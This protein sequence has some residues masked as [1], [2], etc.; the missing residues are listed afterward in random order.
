MK[1]EGGSVRFISMSEDVD[2][3]DVTFFVCGSS[4]ITPTPR[5]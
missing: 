5:P 1:L 3:G 4:N 2:G